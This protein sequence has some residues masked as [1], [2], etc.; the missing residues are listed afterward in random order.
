MSIEKE[1]E[2]M[3]EVSRNPAKDEPEEN[4]EEKVNEN[5]NEATKMPSDNALAALFFSAKT[6]KPVLRKYNNELQKMKLVDDSGKL[7]KDGEKFLKDR[8]VQKKLKEL[9]S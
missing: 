8:E 5:L 6:K 1:L 2:K 7:T 9:S 4:E 3:L